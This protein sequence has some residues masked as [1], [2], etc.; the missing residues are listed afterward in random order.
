M[1]K[2]TR[3][4]VLLGSGAA[5][6][7]ATS[8]MKVAR[9]AAASGEP[10]PAGG[11]SSDVLVIGAGLSGLASAMLLEEAGYDV[12]VIEARDRIG[13]RVFT[14][15]DLPGY[16]EVGGNGFGAGYG[17]VLDMARRMQ[18]EVVEYTERRKR[19]PDIELVVNSKVISADQWAGSKQNPLPEPFRERMPWELPW[20]AMA[21][22]NPLVASDDWR[23]AGNHQYDISLHDFLAARGVP[24]EVIRMG[25]SINPYFGTSA[26]DVSALQYCFNNAWIAAQ[27]K[28]APHSYSILGGN[29]KLPLAMAQQL[30]KPVELEREVS[31]ISMDD[32]G[33]EVHCLDGSV[34]R[35]RRV[36]CSLPY[37]VA[38][39][40]RFDPHLSGTHGIAV[41]NL[42]Y[43]IN[44]VIFL[45]AS[46][47]F[48]EEDGMSPS[49]WTDGLL[50]TMSG[51]RFGKTDEEVTCLVVNPRGHAAAFLDRLPRDE[52]IR[53][54]IAEIERIRPAARGTLKCTGYH[55]WNQDPFAA[56]DWA[57]FAPGQ[58]SQFGMQMASA[59]GCVHFCGEHT[60][61]ANRGMEGAMESAERAAIEVMSAL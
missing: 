49:M 38:R 42:P 30:H 37:S 43:M 10:R 52:A 2:L 17:R 27:A 22:I 8:G 16:P 58:V 14:R 9:A 21:G 12:Q 13:G 1:S 46:R 41:S 36:I 55:S 7:A 31:A 59:H 53:R 25:F 33:A 40:I 26:H 29:Q 45:E 44:T 34:F 4:S 5:V 56:G 32:R 47:P 60:A 11:G 20:G 61:V 23:S 57:V 6:L 19:Y 39:N 35:A 3:R 50:G 28:I 48:W 51:Q 54:V 24:E 15:F 18:L